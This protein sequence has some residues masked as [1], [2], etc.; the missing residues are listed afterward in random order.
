MPSH[1]VSARLSALVILALLGS[2]AP[3]QT[4]VTTYH[5]DMARTGLNPNERILNTANVNSSTFGMLYSLPV[6]GQVYAQ[7]LYLPSVRIPGKGIHNV[8]YVAT[9]HNSVYA[10]DADSNTGPNAKP[11]WHVNFGPSVPNWDTG[12]GDIY[13]EIGI[14]ST[15]VIGPAT[16]NNVNPVLFV[17]SKVKTVDQSNNAVYTQKLHALDTT[18][19]AERLGGPVVVQGSVPGTGDGSV[20]GT[21]TF[22]SL[23]QQSRAALL[24]VPPSTNIVLP[25]AKGHAAATSANGTLYLT[26]ASHGDN[27]P[28]HGWVIAYDA[29]NL[30]QLGI[31]N[32]T[33][34][35]LTD[36]S[37]YPIA[38]GGIWQSGSGPASDGKSIF[39]STGN[40][41]FDPITGSYGDSILRVPNRVFKVADYFTPS[42]QLNLDDY[43][44]D[45]GSGGV[46]LLPRIVG[47]SAH[48][49]LLVQS[50]KEGTLYMLDQA[51]LGKYNVNDVTVQELAY[52]MGGIWGAPAYFNGNV[53]YGPTYSNVLAFPV[54]NGQFTT[55]AANQASPTYFAYPGAG[56]SISSNGNA[57]GIVWAIQSDGYNSGYAANLFAYDATNLGSLLY[58]TT[59]TSGRDILGP[60]VKFAVPTVADGRVFV[61]VDG[62]VGVFG[63]GKWA[64]TPT[65]LPASGTYQGAIQVQLSDATPGAKIFYTTDGSLPTQSSNLY[66][67]PFTL[68]DSANLQVKAFSSGLGQSGIATGTYLINPAIGAGTGLT[69]NYYDNSQNPGGTP[70]VS[71]TD[72]Q[73]DFDWNGNPPVNGVAGSNWAGEWLGQMQAETTATYTLTTLSDDGVQVYINGVKVIDDYNYHAPA[74]DLA[75]ITLQRGVKYNIDIK[76]FQ[77]GGGSVLK[78]YWSAPGIPKTIVPTSQLFPVSG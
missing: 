32:T 22:N 64:A 38:A 3:S 49:N 8:L 47:S 58:G 76:Y 31:L 65:I 37:G 39:F 30:K 6:D 45:L 61:G 17:V 63:L 59:D 50:G 48:P 14:T 16:F 75:T 73:V 70:T 36:P 71:E 34:N 51:N 26:F 66:T 33:P 11:L 52:T 19:G 28:Y 46:M 21:V 5:N 7:P 15:P 43:D 35:G 78:L 4:A 56:I 18:S 55:G 62:S 42:D 27:G 41:K 13:P 23:I 10:F 44:A 25:P 9:E 77:G 60:A 20:N 57:N 2:A 1:A 24:L 12:S 29:G 40:G 69:G 54:K 68:T 74:T 72:P 53:Y 67:G